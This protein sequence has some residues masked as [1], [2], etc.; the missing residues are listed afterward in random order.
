MISIPEA[1]FE[2]E[3][4]ETPGI[5]I[6]HF[7]APWCGLCRLISPILEQVATES[8]GQVQVIGINADE[9]F[10]LVTKYRLRSLPT[11]MVFEDGQLTERLEGFHSREELRQ[12]LTELVLTPVA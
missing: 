7:W 4:L 10:G 8:S 9:N 3:V 1:S 11:L 2:S 12:T 6:V 5:V